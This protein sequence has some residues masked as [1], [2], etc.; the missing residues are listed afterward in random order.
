[1]LI[2]LPDILDPAGVAGLRAVI[3]AGPWA[4][5]NATSGPQAALAKR[6]DQLP[7][8]SG[9]AIEAGRIVLDAL[10]RS[11]LF[12]AAALPLKVYPPLFNRYAGGQAFDTHV[13]NAVRLK[14]GSDF[15]MRSD[16]SLT[17]FLEDPD[18]YDGGELVVEDLYGEQRVKLSAGSAVL[19]PASSLHRVEPVTRGTRVASFLW[20]QSMVRDD[21]ERRILFDLDRAIQRV[22]VEKGQG[23]RSVVELTGVYHNLLRRWA[24]A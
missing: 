5:G 18:A 2:V 23:D 10:G 16:L 22:G 19:Y 7:E 9:A 13:D 15:R 6:N 14:R 24:D 11:P 17:L 12:V 4:D 20:I 1:M 3:D 8:D 21:G